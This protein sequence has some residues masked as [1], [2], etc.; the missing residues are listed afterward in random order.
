VEERAAN[1]R[2]IIRLLGKLQDFNESVIECHT[3]PNEGG[4]MPQAARQESKAIVEEARRDWKETEAV[5]KLLE[6]GK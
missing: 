5:I 4:L 2:R 6:A 3:V 1:R